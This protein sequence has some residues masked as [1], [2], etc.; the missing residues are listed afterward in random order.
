MACVA[1]FHAVRQ[2]FAG[3]TG[4]ANSEESSMGEHQA[5]F[6]C[7]L[8]VRIKVEDSIL[9]KEFAPH[10]NLPVM[11]QIGKFQSITPTFHMSNMT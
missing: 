3:G 4:T 9:W 2:D 7:I 11:Y 10:W 5:H 1:R 8:E 6:I